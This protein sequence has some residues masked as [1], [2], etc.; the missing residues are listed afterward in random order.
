MTAVTFLSDQRASDSPA[1]VR[2]SSRESLVRRE[3]L[4]P[5]RCYP[6]VPG[7]GFTELGTTVTLD[8]HLAALN[9]AALLIDGH[10]ADNVVHIARPRLL[11]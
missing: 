2:Q 8:D 5:S 10:P 1:L 11:R 9:R 3:G 6:Q 7:N 4:E